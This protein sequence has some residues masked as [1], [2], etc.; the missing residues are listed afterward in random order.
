MQLP[1]SAE[2]RP[3]QHV[4][5]VE[6]ESE[7]ADL[8]QHLSEIVEGVAFK[9]SQRSA[10]F[11]T[12]IV[13][14]A[15]AGHF[16]SL[17]ERVIG[18]ELFGRSPSYD[19][20]EDAIVRVTA[21]DVRRRLLQHYG[22]YGSPAGL[23][24]SLPLGS[25]VPMVTRESAPKGDPKSDPKTSPFAETLVH[26]EIVSTHA[27]SRSPH[28]EMQ[29]AAAL[30]QPPHAAPSEVPRANRRTRAA[31]AAVLSALVFFVAGLVAGRE[32]AQR[33][34]LLASLP[35]SVFA[36]SPHATE[37]ITS[38]PTIAEVQE[39]TGSQIS[40]S[41]Y[42]NGSYLPAPGAM[43]PETLRICQLLLRGANPA[44]ID[45]SIAVNIA[46]LGEGLAGKLHVHS[47]RLLRMEDLKTDDNFIFLGSPRSDPWTA[48]FADQLDFRFI[49]DN[50]TGQEVVQNLHPRPR[51]MTEY[52][53][54]AMGG[55]TGQS[56]AIVALV[57]NLDQNG[58]VLLLAGA[59]A[60]G[61]E[62]AAKFVTDL[63]R[64]SRALRDCGIA[65]SG[66]PQHFDFLL[67]LDTMAGSP[68]DYDVVACH[69]SPTPSL[70]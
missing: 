47:A 61:T 38:D 31:G 13:E 30:P 20:G 66:P 2:E 12:Y 34:R 45:T 56:F 39:L 8:R 15:I 68:N 69:L 50:K 55:G 63:P 52:R 24:I 19:T 16:E 32:F 43:S 37:I 26:A 42:A 5:I 25:Y 14:Q 27:E 49:F 7:A 11:L 40:V 28:G 10:Q 44:A 4:G 22:R 35:W 36:N 23:R 41:D 54:T 59:D 57:Q 21:S 46:A 64:F 51:E 62:A 58:Q 67:R 17:K 1:S 18:V 65:R 6:T 53:P 70:H 9:G 60:E 33:D 3:S 48:L 29:Q